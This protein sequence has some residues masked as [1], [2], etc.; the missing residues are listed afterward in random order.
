MVYFFFPDDVFGILDLIYSIGTDELK[1]DASMVL[2][3]T[4]VLVVV[5]LSDIIDT[6][7]L[8]SDASIVWYGMV[9]HGMA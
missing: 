2:Y 9:W 5:S 3:G 7:E 1:I 4:L 8:R 6:D